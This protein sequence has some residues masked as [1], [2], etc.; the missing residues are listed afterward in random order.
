MPESVAELTEEKYLFTFQDETQLWVSR[1]FIEKYPQFP[2]Y[3]IIQ[4]SDKYED[5]S[6]Y[7]DLPFSPM[8]KTIQFLTEDNMNIT[9]LNLKDSYDIYETLLSYPSVISG[10]IRSDLLYHVKQLFLVYLRENH[11]YTYKYCGENSEI[12]TIIDLLNSNAK[13]MHINDPY[14]SNIPLEY[15]CPS[16]IQDIFPSLEKLKISVTSHYKN[17]ELLLNPNSD[18]YIMEYNRLFSAN[19]YNINHPEDFDYFTKSEMNEYNNISFLDRNHI[20]YSYD[21]IDSYNNRKKYY[22]LPKLYKYVVNEAIY[23]DDYSSVEINQEKDEYSNDDSISI[24][25]GDKKYNKIFHIDKVSSKWGISQLLQLCSYFSISEIKFNSYISSKYE[26]MIIMKL[27]GEGVFD[28]LTTLSV[29]WIKYLTNKIDSY[30]FKK[31]MT[32]TVFPNVSELLYDDDNRSS[33]LA[34]LKKECFSKLYCINFLYNIDKMDFM[35]LHFINILS[36][37]G[38]I[39]IN[40]IDFT[41]NRNLV[42]LL[43]NLAYTY[44]IHIDGIDNFIYY[45]PHLKE[46]LERDLISIHKL[47]INSSDCVNIKKLDYVIN[48]K[49]SIDCFDITFQNFR[50]NDDNISETDVRNSLKKFLNVSLLE[51]LNELTIKLPNIRKN[52]SSEYLSIYENILE[53]LIP[54]ASIV[55]INNCT[56]NVINELIFKGCFRQTNQLTLEINYIPDENFCELYTKNNFHQ[57]NTIK[58]NTLQTKKLWTNFMLKFGNYIHNNNF[59]SST[60]IKLSDDYCSDYIYDHNTSILRCKYDSNSSMDTLIGTQNKQISEYEI[61]ALFD[62]INENKTQYLRYLEIYVFNEE[63]LSKLIDLINNGKIPKLKE[64]NIIIGIYSCIYR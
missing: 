20:Y 24:E 63:Q 60:T 52:L 29:Q 46:L 64:L 25:Y 41:Q 47:C 51:H 56:I 16:C 38:S 18:E 58:F 15:I 19:R 44:S 10:E 61:E 13:R 34:L 32:T 7:M 4:H 53:K 40:K 26:A 33:Y 12:S 27:F 35:S 57:L 45:I 3:D 39:Q 14:A 11:F 50:Q 62:C 36:M 42:S 37:I 49:H 59:P 30:L 43:D 28:S 1:E 31:I 8:K 17:S 48:Y 22:E 5:D 9:S 55:R 6:Y 23:S 54:K 21:L 2:F